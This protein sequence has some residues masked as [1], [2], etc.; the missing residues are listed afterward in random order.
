M[1]ISISDGLVAL[2]SLV[3]VLDNVLLLQL[4]HTL[5]LIQVDNK[6]FVVAMKRLDTLPAENI[7]VVGAVKMF[8]A[9]RMNL[10]QLL[11]EALLIFVLKVEASAC[12]NRILLHNFVKDIDVEGQ[13]LST[14][15]I[16]DQLATDRAPHTIFVMQ[17][18]DAVRAEGVPTVD[19]D[20][21]NTLANVVLE[22]A[23]LAD[24]KTTRLV[25]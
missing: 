23:E 5:N 14:L 22:P 20:A 12:Q 18:R 19:Q 9:L 4:A 7:Q 11:R 13:T 25:V 21:R 16:L 24:V 1:E 6:A 15:Q 2:A 8:D 10:A 17:L 3:D